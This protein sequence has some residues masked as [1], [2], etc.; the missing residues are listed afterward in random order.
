MTP[1]THIRSDLLAI[2]GGWMAM[3]F[4]SAAAAMFFYFFLT[5]GQ[6][7]PPVL[8]IVLLLGALL[9]SSQVLLIRALRRQF[10]ARRAW[11][12]T[13]TCPADLHAWR[14]AWT[15]LV[16]AHHGLSV[17]PYTPL[18]I[19]PRNLTVED[20]TVA[21]VPRAVRQHVWRQTTDTLS[22]SWHER[23]TLAYLLQE[24]WTHNIPYPYCPPSAHQRLRAAASVQ[25]RAT[26]LRLAAL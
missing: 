24:A 2:L 23:G 8:G 10:W 17:P 7:T 3:T 26:P 16:L 20:H 15:T 13:D 14:Q 19:H 9:L 4:L 18:C 1:S 11:R 6:D 21:P 5:D 25:S 12:L 22:L